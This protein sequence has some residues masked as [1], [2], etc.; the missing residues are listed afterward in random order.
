MLMEQIIFLDRYATCST[1]TLIQQCFNTCPYGLHKTVLPKAVFT[2]RVGDLKYMI[3]QD[4]QLDKCNHPENK[5]KPKTWPSVWCLAVIL[6]L[7]T[8]VGSCHHLPRGTG[9]GQRACLPGLPCAES[10]PN[11]NSQLKAQKRVVFRIWVAH[12]DKKSKC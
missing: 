6:V 10:E 9:H 7:G 4:L 12:L 3:L 11:P 8:K 1:E 5:Q 2:N